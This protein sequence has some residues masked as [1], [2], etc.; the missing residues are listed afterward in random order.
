MKQVFKV[1]LYG[2][3]ALAVAGTLAACNG[4]AGAEGQ[5]NAGSAQQAA[6]PQYAR[7]ISS[8]PITRTVNHPS[9]QCHNETVTH[10]KPAKDTH[11]IA[12]TA[13]GAVLGGVLGHQ[14]GGGKGKTLATVAGAVGGGY[15]GKKI[16]EHVQNNNTYTTNERKCQT[17]NHRTTQVV[18]Y[19]VTYSYNGTRHTTRMNHKPGDRIRVK[20]GVQPVSPN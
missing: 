15:A 12:G 13:I 17:V 18:G 10:H 4:N 19:K 1:T 16:E 2:G 11:Q 3:L 20:S 7:V 14:V 5:Q 6:G 9:Q 8:K